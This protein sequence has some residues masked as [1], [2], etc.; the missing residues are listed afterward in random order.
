MGK[1]LGPRQA[2]PNRARSKNNPGGKRDGHKTDWFWYDEGRRLESQ[3]YVRWMRRMADIAPEILG[4]A[5]WTRDRREPGRCAQLP[6]PYAD[7]VIGPDRPCN[8][9]RSRRIHSELAVTIDCAHCPAI[10]ASI[11][12]EENLLL[13][14]G[15]AF[16]Q[17]SRRPRA[18]RARQ[19][20]LRIIGAGSISG[21]PAGTPSPAPCWPTRADSA[22]PDTSAGRTQSAAGS[23][24]GRSP[25]CA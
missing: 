17:I 6:G 14:P 23:A 13:W 2:N 16:L 11:K 10:L 19:T 15:Q 7:P 18:A 1:R 12:S 3:S 4:M 5:P 8:P 9:P 20:A 21:W 24:C 25:S 22:R